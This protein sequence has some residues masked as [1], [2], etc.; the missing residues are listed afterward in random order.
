MSGYL[1]DSLINKQYMKIKRRRNNIV[2]IDTVI[3]RMVE[4]QEETIGQYNFQTAKRMNNSN[5][6]TRCSL[7]S[8]LLIIR[9]LVS[10]ITQ[11]KLRF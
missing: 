1:R 11:T 2:N 4:K 6:R 7:V 8:C 9:K 5:L 3:I 10:K